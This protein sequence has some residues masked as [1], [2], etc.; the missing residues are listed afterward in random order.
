MNEIITKKQV[1]NTTGTKLGEEF[2]SIGFKYIKSK[3]ELVRENEEGEDRIV[4]STY[5]S[6]S[7]SI[8]V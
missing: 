3:Q 5:D 4:F 1:I 7:I 2:S 6:Y 8:Q